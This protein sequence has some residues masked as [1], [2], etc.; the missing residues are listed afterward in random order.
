M[1]RNNLALAIGVDMQCKT[2]KMKN[3]GTAVLMTST[4]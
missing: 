3:E 4:K 2:Q 1:D